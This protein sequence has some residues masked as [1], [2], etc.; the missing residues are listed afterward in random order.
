MN[1]IN[2]KNFCESKNFELIKIIN[3]NK[4]K[5]S[6][7]LLVK[8]KND[9]NFVIKIYGN[10]APEEIKKSFQIEINFYKNFN[11]NGIPK[12]F[13]YGNH[14][15]ILEYFEGLSLTES[16]EKF[17]LNPNKF[18]KF[19]FSNSIL[20]TFDWFYDLKS[21]IHSAKNNQKKFIIDSFLDRLGNLL[22]SGLKDS[23]KSKLESFF[24]RR[25]YKNN[26][27]LLEMGLTKIVDYWIND[28]LKILSFYGHNDLH[29]NNVLV[30][31]TLSKIKLIDFENIKSPGIWIC[32]IIY[33]YGTLF[34][35]FS[36]KKEL[37]NKIKSYALNY[38]CTKEPNFNKNQIE[39][40]IDIFCKAA[41][42]NSRFRLYDEGIKITKMLEYR[43][44]IRSL[45]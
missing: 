28:N 38:I 2:F 25:F 10:N 36:P 11:F 44:S 32:D 17:F 3:F 12:L 19:Y 45:I 8:S 9:Q 23:K 42:S 27:K 31:Q 15:F 13:D 1:K 43:N 5:D 33:F 7:I 37:Q 16:V 30:D 40:I 14:F 39:I 26:F 34:A 24:L 22:T 41:A 21:G 29:G 18:D 20:S 4:R 6:A 35:L